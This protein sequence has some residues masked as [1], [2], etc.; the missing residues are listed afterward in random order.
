M[1]NT[2]KGCP[3]VQLYLETGHN[4]ARLEIQTYRLMYMHYILQQSD[5]STI[6][7]FFNLKLE[8]P[9]R[10]DWAGMC[11]Q[12]LTD[13]S[14]DKSLEVIKQMTKVQFS[15]LVKEK[16]RRKA[17]EYLTGK[18]GT[19]GKEMRYENLEMSEYLLPSTS[20]LT[21]EERR[22]LFS[23]RNKM[24]N[25]SNNFPKS[26]IKEKCSCGKIEDMQHI[27]E[28][29]QLNTNSMDK[30]LRYEKIYNG[31]ISDQIKVFRKMEIN[32]EN[33]KT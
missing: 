4:P 11:R 17:I 15:K 9:T 25:I 13:L 30:S 12:D 29:E 31:N 21:I 28:C 32:L 23:M 19:K 24:V 20:A 8:Q 5:N 7:K 26:D 16:S 6:L 27:Y 18:Q 22:T 33:E 3:I 10:G 2:S 1:F 14:I